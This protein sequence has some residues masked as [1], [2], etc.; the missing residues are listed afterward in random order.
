M[1]LLYV[2][3]L[4]I[5]KTK[6][7]KRLL[8]VFLSALKLL[9]LQRFKKKRKTLL[10]GNNKKVYIQDLDISTISN[11]I[12]YKKIKSFIEVGRTY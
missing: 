7:K 1:F 12:M 2:L 11:G 8:P 6:G 10:T 5:Y 9:D 3:I 4:S